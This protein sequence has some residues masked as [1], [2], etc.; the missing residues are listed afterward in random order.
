[1]ND[2]SPVVQFVGAGPGAADLL[3]VRAARMLGD[4]EVVLYPGSYHDDDLLA[5]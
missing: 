3:T 1:M 5:H 4:A 2:E